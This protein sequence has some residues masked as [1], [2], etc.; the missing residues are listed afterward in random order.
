MRSFVILTLTLSFLIFG[1][2]NLSAQNGLYLEWA[3]SF[4]SYGSGGIQNSCSKLVVD[5][6]ENII[7][8][9]NFRGQVDFDTG[10]GQHILSSGA[11]FDNYICKLNSNSELIWVK[12]IS[13]TFTIGDIIVDEFNNI[14]ITGS[15]EDS[16]DF[17]PGPG[18]FFLYADFN[19][20][21]FVLKLDSSGG[22]L[23]AKHFDGG[24]STCIGNAIE[25]DS[26]NNIYISGQFDGIIDF[27]PD[28]GTYFLT[29]TGNQ[30]SDFDIFIVKLNET[31]L[32]VSGFQIG[33]VGGTA[34]SQDMS[35]NKSSNIIITG[36]FSDTVDFNPGIGV[37]YL[38]GSPNFLSMFVLCLDSNLNFNWVKGVMGNS[39]VQG[40]SISVDNSNNV[41]ITGSFRGTADFDPGFGIFNLYNQL[42]Y[43]D[44]IFILKLDQNANF[45]WAVGFGSLN[46]DRGLIIKT[47]SLNSVY[48]LGTLMDSID[49][50]PGI[51]TL[52]LSTGSNNNTDIFV[53]V[54]DS[55]GNYL[56][57]GIYGYSFTCCGDMLGGAHVSKSG[58]LICAGGFNGTVDFDLGT[59]VY[60]I[61]SVG[62]GNTYLFKH[63]HSIDIYIP[64]AEFSA[65]TTIVSPSSIIIF[66][67]LSLN[68]PVS[69][70]W[71]FPGGTPSVSSSQNPIIQYNTLGSYDVTLIVGNAFGS[72]TITKP[73]YI[74]VSED[75]FTVWISTQP[76]TH[77]YFTTE[78]SLGTFLSNDA[79]PNPVKICSDGSKATIIRI[80]SSNS[81]LNLQN[82][83]FRVLGDTG[84]DPNYYGS[85]QFPGDYFS[86]N[87]LAGV[88]FTHPTFNGTT[89]T[90]RIDTI[91]AYDINNPA[92]N[93][94]VIPVAFYRA[95]ILF[96]HG[97]WGNV[98]SFLDM[99]NYFNN[100]FGASNLI[101]RVADYSA[102]NASSF[103]T[104]QFKVRDNLIMTLVTAQVNGFSSGKVDVVAHSMGGV[105]S[106]LYLQSFGYENDIHT[107]TTI[108]TPHSGTQSANLLLSIYG[109]TISSTLQWSGMCVT[110]GAVNDLKINNP[111]FA[112]NL[113][114]N[115]RKVPSL[116][117]SSYSSFVNGS[118]W[119]PFQLCYG[120]NAV[121]FSFISINGTFEL[122]TRLFSPYAFDPIVPTPSQIAATNFQQYQEVLHT[123]AQQFPLLFNDLKTK[124][125]E[126]PITTSAYNQ[127]GFVRANLRLPFWM[128][129][130]I[131]WRPSGLFIPD[132]IEIITPIDSSIYNTSDSVNIIINRASGIVN[133]IGYSLINNDDILFTDLQFTNNLSS[134][135][136]LPDEIC[137]WVRLN[138]FGL[139]SSGGTDVDS[140]DF[141][142]NV[143]ASLV[144]MNFNDSLLIISEGSNQ[145]M[146][147]FGIYSDTITRNISS[148]PGMNYIIIDSSIVL[149]TGSK[150]LFANGIG[151]TEV[152]ASYQGFTD[153]LIVIVHAGSNLNNANFALSNNVVC[154][155]AI[156]NFTDQ[157]TGSPISWEWQFP[158]GSPSFSVDQNPNIIYSTAGLYDVTMIVT[159]A[160]TTDTLYIPDYIIVSDSPVA[161]I[162]PLGSF[163]ICEG[164]SIIL[165][166][167]GRIGLSYFWSTFDTTQT[168]MVSDSGTFH[169]TVIDSVGC[170]GISNN[171]DIE[172]LDLP[173]V[174]ISGNDTICNGTT[175]FLDA[176]SGFAN[177]VW[178]NG[179]V[180]PV[181]AI[182]DSGTY[183]VIVTDSSGCSNSAN[184]NVTSI[185][186]DTTVTQISDTLM[187]LSGLS[188]YQ[189]VSCPSM[190]FVSG[191]TNQSFV[192]GITGEYAV[193][194]TQSGCTDTSNCHFVDLISGINS[195]NSVTDILL[196]PNPTNANIHLSAKQISNG[197]YKF[198]IFNLLNQVNY[199]QQSQVTN[200]SLELKMEV[201]FL[202]SG[203]YFLRI[204]SDAGIK[205]LPIQKL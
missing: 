159:W 77:S 88:R 128:N 201:S 146:T 132:P 11:Y 198:E 107:L 72:D 185:V 78:K 73:N 141:L 31:G 119:I 199:T 113:N 117:Y 164:D 116:I 139:N 152:I 121:T 54:L 53:S 32:F 137:G 79:P 147:V 63:N 157:S 51:D 134:S 150:T 57:A 29:S 101:M 189:W 102:T 9:G 180:T 60:N 115:N 105:L 14:I 131:S 142:V 85:F 61:S 43:K 122:A 46:Q 170:I 87:Q 100:Q 166:T 143:S 200:G 171:T 193:I 178:S 98:S 90:P 8:A 162:T 120:S 148:M 176:G 184:F 133:S 93:L 13:G 64:Q 197:F 33:G 187:A 112:S 55:N 195:F 44:D 7:V 24:L 169:V 95:P 83:R 23:W 56:N 66:T 204:S 104:N 34:A 62:G 37:N 156:I 179:A 76:E 127:T 183:S 154:D 80:T 145:N 123:D 47:D 149:L 177:Y 160:D 17:D 50:N 15:F 181:I 182:S 45:L 38:N 27:D 153:T 167:N 144:E 84:A 74:T 89:T 194:L 40:N 19:S 188:Y 118:D 172:I 21:I 168:I 202:N 151:T 138:A 125:G 16:V 91:V 190:N 58:D 28:S 110:C 124:L 86:T 1:T 71:L 20:D 67:D 25:V 140:V 70:N 39:Y 10:T 196:F 3:K 18:S 175:G 6:F 42:T 174:D 65:N 114:G 111:Y 4:P 75:T 92:I 129:P 96:V 130:N 186:I 94:I 191:A 41:L 135:Y 59:N 103:S 106:R 26:L 81:S 203:Y 12:Q 161:T 49:F 2:I 97:L 5:N 109:G 165:S 35:F 173:I 36:Y 82:I 69:W 205:V 48:T 192:P 126:N 136:L 52:M 158:G 22:F 99:R 108:N 163:S 155:S 68:S 30:Q